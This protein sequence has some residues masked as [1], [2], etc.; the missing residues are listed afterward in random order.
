L[1]GLSSGRESVELLI[2]GGK[3]RLYGGSGAKGNEDP[4]NGDPNV[5]RELEKLESNGTE[6]SIGEFSVGES[7]E[8]KGLHQ[9][10]GKGR[11]PVSELITLKV[12]GGGTVTEEVELMLLNAIFHL[13]SGTVK[14]TV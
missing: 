11:E 7:F 10:I 5:S 4:S 9:D 14:V 6:L 3:N 1:L 13:A 12:M 8:T 2:S